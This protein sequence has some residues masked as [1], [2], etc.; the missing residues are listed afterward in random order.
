M[1]WK[2]IAEVT[3]EPAPETY[4]EKKRYLLR[5]GIALW[6]MC[7]LCVRSGSLDSN[8][9]DEVPNDILGFVAA[10]PQLKV[11]GCNGGK[12]ANMYKKDVGSI[13]GVEMVELPSSSPANAGI[14]WEVKVERWGKMS[15]FTCK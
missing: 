13:A 2:L 7:A 11:I 10:H 15:L 9:T 1:F 3:G 14:K 12:A 8:I 4:E 5:H 6:D